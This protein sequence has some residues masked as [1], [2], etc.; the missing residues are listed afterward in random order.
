VATDRLAQ[1]LATYE[2]PEIDPA[3]EDALSAYVA[4]QK[5]G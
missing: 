3:I 1:R 5:K 2:K 4:R